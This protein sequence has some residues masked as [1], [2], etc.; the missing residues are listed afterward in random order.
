MDGCFV[1]KKLLSYR[2]QSYHVLQTAA[3]TATAATAAA[4]AAAAAAV[5]LPT[6]C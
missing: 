4:I 1:R 5:A 2:S 3:T 6:S